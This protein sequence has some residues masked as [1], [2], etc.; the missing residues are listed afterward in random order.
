MHVLFVLATAQLQVI[1]MQ[2][3]TFGA[4]RVYNKVEVRC[5]AE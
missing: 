5:L 3:F 4:N 2:S 1:I